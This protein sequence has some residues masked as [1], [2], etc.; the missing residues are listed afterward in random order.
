[1]PAFLNFAFPPVLW[2]ATAASAPVI[3]HLIMRTKPRRIKFP[4]IE[5][6]K[7]THQANISMHRL[8]HL[9]LLLMRMTAIALLAL[10]VARA[11]LAGFRASSRT[12]EPAAAAVVIDNSG[13]MDYRS[14][15]ETHLARAKRL[16]AE[17]IATLPAGSRVAVLSAASP[18]RCIGFSGE[19]EDAVEQ[20]RSVEG[21]W[22]HTSAARAMSHAMELLNGVEDLQRKEVYVVTD[23]TAE[24]WRDGSGVHP[25]QD[26]EKHFTLIDVGGE[27]L[28]AALGE[29]RLSAWSVPAEAEVGIRTTARR[30]A[31]APELAVRVELDGQTANE[32]LLEHLA[33]G[34]EAPLALAVKAGTPGVAAGKVLLTGL[35]EADPLPMDN[36]RHFTLT[37]GSPAVLLVVR[38][39]TTATGRDMTSIHVEA[40]AA[41]AGGDA[42]RGE[43]VVRQPITADRL[44][45][46]RLRGTGGPGG[47]PGGRRPRIV[48]LVNVSSLTPEQWE[49]L[50]AY[51]NDGGKLWVVT[52]DLVAPRGYNTPE[53]QAL[54]PV[55]LG[56]MEQLA[57]P[58]P[59]R[60]AKPSHPLLAP[61]AG[62]EGAPPAGAAATGGG[63]MSLAFVRSIRRFAVASDV[64]DAQVV[65]RYDDGVPAVIYR[66]VGE[67]QV[68]FWNFS[69]A[70]TFSNWGSYE[71]APAFGVL[72]QRT[73]RLLMSGQGTM[74]HYGDAVTLRVPRELAGA[75]AA[76]RRPG[77]KYEPVGLDPGGRTVTI[78]RADEVGQWR[79]RFSPRG[80]AG[81]SA[82]GDS[83]QVEHGFSVNV[84]YAES[85][86]K[87]A[88]LAEIQEIFPPG[89]PVIV[90]DV[91]ELTKQAETIRGDLDLTVPLLLAVVALATAESFFANRF[92]RRPREG[93]VSPDVSRAASRAAE[94]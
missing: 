53:A 62:F 35:G 9:L 32:R 46:E 8:K 2:A 75:A 45:A 18:E 61:F 25:K 73:L 72:T 5:F 78:A 37:V 29:L 31:Q 52:G 64:E 59:W 56:A 7:R 57:R 14:K 24:F 42:S 91:A 67:G 47:P 6:V 38:D 20:V 1:M 80:G 58:M 79:V 94:D 83:G 11:A 51:V 36:E 69:P 48:L 70:A 44:D 34:T 22:G 82:A 71:G 10:L 85:N 28:N 4:A 27:D 26:A 30:P 93:S 33:A 3:I 54:V 39:R 87:R 76:V 66:D 90:K 23:M 21:T 84:P 50:G 17:V 43:W 63:G 49:A 15:G 55:E 19:A 86:L 13:S 92:Y 77:G 88:A 89:E 65:F 60:V 40:A 68:V 16:A 81:A 41:P 12:A 74:F